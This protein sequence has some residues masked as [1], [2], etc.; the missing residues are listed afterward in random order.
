MKAI[1]KYLVTNTS[2]NVQIMLWGRSMGAVTAIRYIAETKN[3]NVRL[4]VVD[5]PFLSLKGLILELIY[6]KMGLPKFFV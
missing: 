1:L 5:S 3:P 6:Q 2:E 4:A